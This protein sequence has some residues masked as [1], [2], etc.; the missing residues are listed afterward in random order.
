[1]RRPLTFAVTSVLVAAVQGGCSLGASRPGAIPSGNASDG[2]AGAAGAGLPPSPGRQDGQAMDLGDNAGAADDATG[3]DAALG[4]FVINL[5]GPVVENGVEKTPAYT[6]VFGRIFD[7]APPAPVA[8]KVVAQGDGC[9]LLTPMVPFCNAG[10]GG[11]AACVEG[12]TCVE[13]PSA[14]SL[15]RVHVKGLAGGEFDMEE[16]AGNYQPSARIPYPPLPE[17][18]KVEITAPGG[19]L[20]PLRLE[21]V[22]IAPLE[23]AAK[24]Q[25]VAGQPLVLAWK[26]PAQANVSRIEV[27]MDLSHHGGS[28][29]K[30]ECDVADTGGLAIPAAQITTLLGFGIS[31][32]P[33]VVVTRVASAGTATRL[34]RAT[35]RVVASVE[36]EVAI[37]GLHS[38][39]ANADCP[40]GMTCQVDLQ[41]K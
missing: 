36:R 21:S 7:R 18:G 9:Q 26:P 4:G 8:W 31:G 40:A 20:G 29:G 2:T 1:M 12:G 39:T 25:P 35:L 3:G 37:E 23:F 28:K 30:I 38:C 10:C 14:V 13:Y 6:A 17:G 19:A 27:T 32:F 34:G 5:V 41:C 11:S 15:G 16:V 33:T 24:V 22:G